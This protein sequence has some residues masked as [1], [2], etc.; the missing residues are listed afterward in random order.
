[1]KENEFLSLGLFCGLTKKETLMST[2]GEV[3]D[4]VAIKTAGHKKSE[5]E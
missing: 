3:F 1:M 4:L 2:P 5:E